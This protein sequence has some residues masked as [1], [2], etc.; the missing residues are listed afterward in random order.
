M[1]DR[2]KKMPEGEDDKENGDDEPASPSSSE[3]IDAISVPEVDPS[4]NSGELITHTGACV[5]VCC[6]LC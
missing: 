4:E 2:Q 6:C 3:H 5:Y 1:D